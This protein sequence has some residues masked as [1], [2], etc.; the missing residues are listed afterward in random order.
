MDFRGRE[1]WRRK[2][3]DQ[4]LLGDAACQAQE[5]GTPHCCVVVLKVNP[6]ALDESTL[7]LCRVSKLFTGAFG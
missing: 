2:D 6:I 5:E 4:L 3:D 7:G 1:G